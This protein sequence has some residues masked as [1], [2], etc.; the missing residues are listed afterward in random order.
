[1]TDEANYYKVIVGKVVGGKYQ[2]VD[3]IGKGVFGVVS[4]AKVVG[5]DNVCALKI[6]RKN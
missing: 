5:M 3:K 2:I 1:M 4:K 6:I